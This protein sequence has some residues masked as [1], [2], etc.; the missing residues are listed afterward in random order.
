[1]RDTIAKCK[2]RKVTDMKASVVVSV[3]I[4]AVGTAAFAGWKDW[5]PEQV[6]AVKAWIKAQKTGDTTILQRR[7]NNRLVRID[8]VTNDV[9]LDPVAL[10]ARKE[11]KRI[12]DVVGITITDTP[13]QIDSKLQA[14]VADAE[15]SNDIKLALYNSSKFWTCWMY[16]QNINASTNDQKQVTYVPVFADSF[17]QSNNLG[18]VVGNDIEAVQRVN[19]DY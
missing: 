6:A 19:N 1:M 18:A 14:Y 5:T 13:A 4:V 11:L 16:V 15:S 17:A 2:E 12:A 7:I 8:A 3:V 9:P 10:I